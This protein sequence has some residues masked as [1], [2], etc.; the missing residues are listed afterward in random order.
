[1]ADLIVLE[2]ILVGGG[3]A[4]AAVVQPGPLQ[5]FLI[6]RVAATGWRRTLP[7]CLAPVLSDAPIALL[8]LLVLGRLSVKIQYILQA[9]GGILLL[10]LAWTSFRQW[11]HPAAA[12][13]HRSAPRTLFE[14]VLVN[15]LNPNPYLGWA[16]V[17]GPAVLAAWHE[18]PAYAVA[19]VG[20][21][22]CTMVAM[23]ALFIVLVGT[24]RFLGTRAQHA[25][26]AVSAVAL[27]GLGAYLL[28]TAVQHLAAA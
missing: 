15:V 4:F 6:S 17:L 26:V 21:F 10:Y 13:A 28:V 8:A 23:L 16:L 1:V 7:A 24:A 25:L 19:L 14:A 3:Y 2:N 11:R 27:A 12:E 22:Y 5:A 18:H 20:A 9:G